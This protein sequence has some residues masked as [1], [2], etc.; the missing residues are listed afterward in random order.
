M[1]PALPQGI[2]RQHVSAMAAGTTVPSRPASADAAATA[3]GTGAS[4]GKDGGTV[5]RSGTMYELP[6]KAAIAS[7]SGVAAASGSGAGGSRGGTVQLKSA[8]GATYE[9][10]A[11]AAGLAQELLAILGGGGGG[12]GG[13]GAGGMAAAAGPSRPKGMLPKPKKPMH[14]NLRVPPHLQRGAP[15]AAAPVAATVL[16]FNT[17]APEPP[18]L[19][20]AGP[21]SR[22]AVPLGLVPEPLGLVLEPG[23]GYQSVSADPQRIAASV[24]VAAA[25]QPAGLASFPLMH[26]QY[27]SGGAASAT[28]GG[29][30][31]QSGC[32]TIG[33]SSSSPV[34]VTGNGRRVVIS[35]DALVRGR[36]ML[37]LGDGDGA[38][39]SADASHDIV[40]PAQQP[41]LRA[42]FKR[43]RAILA[44]PRETPATIPQAADAPVEEGEEE[45]KGR[46][47]RRGIVFPRAFKP[48]AMTL[49]APLEAEEGENAGEA[50]APAADGG[51]KAEEEGAPA[52]VAVEMEAGQEAGKEAEGPMPAGALGVAEPPAPIDGAEGAGAG[53]AQLAKEA[54]TEHE[55]EAV[56][57]VEAEAATEV[58]AAAEATEAEGSVVTGAAVQGAEAQVAGLDKAEA[59]GGVE[60]AADPL[61]EIDGGGSAAKRPRTDNEAAGLAGASDPAPL[62]VP[63]AAEAAAGVGAAVEPGGEGSAAKRPRT[64]G[65]D[66][67]SG[68][69]GSC[70]ADKRERE[71]L[72]NRLED[73]C[74][75]DVCVPLQALS[76]P[77][78]APP[79]LVGGAYNEV[80]VTISFPCGGSNLK[81]AVVAAACEE[82]AVRQQQN[83]LAGHQ[84]YNP[85]V[86]RQGLDP[87]GLGEEASERLQQQQPDLQAE[88][89]GA[90]SPPL[91]PERLQPQQP[92]RPKQAAGDGAEELPPCQPQAAGGRGDDRPASVSPRK[93][94]AEGVPGP[95]SAVSGLD[96]PSTAAPVTAPPSV[97]SGP[98]PGSAGLA[99]ASG[100]LPPTPSSDCQPPAPPLLPSPLSRAPMDKVAAGFSTA[101]GRVV[102]AARLESAATMLREEPSPPPP[103]SP[104]PLPPP[105]QLQQQPPAT[106]SGDMPPP[107]PRL[108]SRSVPTGFST[109]RGRA[110]EVA[111]ARLDAAAAMLG[112]RTNV[113]SDGE[114][115]PPPPPRLPSGTVPTGFSTARG[116]AVEVAASRLEAAATMLGAAMPAAVPG[117]EL[118]ALSGRHTA[119]ATE[120]D[121]DRQPAI[122]E[123]A[124]GVEAV[125]R[126]LAAVPLECSTL[127]ANVPAAAAGVEASGRQLAAGELMMVPLVPIQ[128]PPPPLPPQG[129]LASRALQVPQDPQ[130]SA[131]VPLPPPQGVVAGDE[132]PPAGALGGA[133]SDRCGAI[134]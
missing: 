104:L 119:A 97:P 50:A 111:A 63:M 55:T 89:G 6:A 124:V 81:K 122:E 113:L 109:A 64:G 32:A 115:P 47:S 27:Q 45:L 69:S 29:S 30:L 101:S 106:S 103:L 15:A 102:D 118:L 57:E 100:G 16:A 2:A 76:S 8:T 61:E 72:A 37:D 116:R 92:C 93:R 117:D 18:P 82:P 67:V 126:Q 51:E 70:C 107:P 14:A 114:M 74:G 49:P 54:Q 3:S 42:S 88:D 62:N 66:D 40:G 79:Q 52:P 128:P 24:Q 83:N 127:A 44:A 33:E 58:E 28:I 90:V 13:E 22:G 5:L 68:K 132:E 35:E 71:G 31:H 1:A 23:H 38:A 17:A 129:A 11:K 120:R 121:E 56:A 134:Y 59:E 112:A 94:K 96:H 125:S 133:P 131:A 75:S 21:G 123:R 91:V 41:P 99:A 65:D 39:A 95:P 36:N 130:D 98:A 48:P 46:D 87:L 4:G 80:I 85:T 34:F 12:S 7:S 10:P 26:H 73:I 84:Q 60:A 108:P 110:V 43:P 9:V 78:S 77:P 19:S 105:P 53:H 25:P 20:P 86:P